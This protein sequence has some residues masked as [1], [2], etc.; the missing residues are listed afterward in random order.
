MDGGVLCGVAHVVDV[1]MGEDEVVEGVGL[2]GEMP[3]VIYDGLAGTDGAVRL[4]RSG[5]MLV[6]L[7]IGAGGIDKEGSA[8]R[9]D[10]KTALASSGINAMDVQFARLPE[11]QPSRGRAREC[12]YSIKKPKHKYFVST[13][14][15]YKFV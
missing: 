3:D 9:Q 8:V 1:I 11:A 13:V 14:K 4:G 15:A 2:G 10:K 5:H 6:L 7:Q 12:K